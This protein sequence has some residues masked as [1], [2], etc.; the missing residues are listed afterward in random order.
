MDM[1]LFYG[2]APC[3]VSCCGCFCRSRRL[4]YRNGEFLNTLL[5][6]SLHGDFPKSRTLKCLL[7]PWAVGT[8]PGCHT[9]G[10]PCK[11]TV[12]D[13]LDGRTIGDISD[14]LLLVARCP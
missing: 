11:M 9:A 12:Q 1:T 2:L 8:G 7:Q 6:M 4:T 10:Q 3:D 13:K 14:C 5:Y